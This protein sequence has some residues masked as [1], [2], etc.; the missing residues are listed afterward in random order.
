MNIFRFIL[1]T[2]ICMPIGMMAQK[3]DS[4]T[5]VQQP[6]QSTTENNVVEY[7]TKRISSL[8]NEN[9][10]LKEQIDQLNANKA[11][12]AKSSEAH[13]KQIEDSLS[14]SKKR[15]DEKSTELNKQRADNDSLKK[16][17]GN[18]DGVIYKECLLYP[19]SIR[20]NQQRI[21]ECLNALK[22]Y[23][24]LVDEEHQS[25]ELKQCIKVYKP[26]LEGSPSSYLTYTNEIIE[27]LG[28]MVAD[29]S[30]VE[31]H[32][33]MLKDMKEQC[34][35]DIKK[36]KYYT[37]YQNRDQAPY[38]SIEFLDN[39]LDHLKLLINESR[40]VAKDINI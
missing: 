23:C 21:N 12:T 20:Y 32:P 15:I 40:N 4:T 2:G 18:L 5:T 28:N 7:L 13:T 22:T 6:V 3:K 33:D 24:K 38:K 19:L 39:A 10:S 37:L 16:V 34:V 27:V 8:E 35:G 17:L 1:L 30:R 14:F 36:L 29:L 25:E 9:K 11:E 31:N 26:F